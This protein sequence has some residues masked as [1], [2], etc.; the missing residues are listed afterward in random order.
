MATSTTSLPRARPRLQLPDAVSVLAERD[1]R[2]VWIGQAVSMCGTW[3]QM[4]AQGLLVLELWDHA[5]ALGAL[6]FAN[7]VPTLLIMLFGGVLADRSDKRRILL[8][9]QAIMMMLA[10]SVGVLILVEPTRR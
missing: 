2:V 8:A 1:F 4:V 9:T 6:N 3:M 10:L 5:F 7:A